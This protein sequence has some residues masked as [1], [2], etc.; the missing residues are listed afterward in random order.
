VNGKIDFYR[1]DL[2]ELTAK[3]MPETYI[4]MN[5]SMDII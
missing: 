2:I 1:N 3:C 5:T 4:H